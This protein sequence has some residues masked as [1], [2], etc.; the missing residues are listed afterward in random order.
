MRPGDKLKNGAILIAREND[1]VLAM[2]NRYSVHME[3]ITWYIDEDGDTSGGQYF[4][5]FKQAVNDF[6]KRSK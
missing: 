4:I 1:I 3:Y 6:Y 5:D 2:W